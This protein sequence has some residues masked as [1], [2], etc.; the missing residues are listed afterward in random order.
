[1]ASK[2]TVPLTGS[3]K[4]PLPDARVIAPAPPDERLEVTVRL[5]P[6]T[7]LPDPASLLQ[8]SKDPA[9][10]LTRQEYNARYGAD[11]KD[12]AR[13]RRFAAAHHLTVVRVSA[14]RRSVMLAGTVAD[15][16]NAFNVDLHTYAYP[17]GTYRGREGAIRVPSELAPAVEGVFGLDNRP[18]ARRHFRIARSTTRQA[19]GAQPFNP[20]D[21]AKLYNYPVGTDGRGQTV[22]I[23]EL[24]GGFRFQDLQAYLS[25]L[26]V[27]VPTVVPISVDGATNAPSGDPGSDDGEVGLDIEVV[28]AVAPGA[29]VVVYFAPNSRTS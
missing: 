11:P 5:R 9:P 2:K 18:V 27:A 4:R 6:K 14:P 13:V 29:K 21:V 22:G 10:I 7:P 12:V 17:G 3:E 24:G 1:M 19:D 26:G 25:G 20:S 23:I 15:F 28:A 8:P 16:N